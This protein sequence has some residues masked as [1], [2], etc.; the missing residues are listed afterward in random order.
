MP[1]CK[2]CCNLVEKARYNDTFKAT[3]LEILCAVI[4]QLQEMQHFNAVDNSLLFDAGAGLDIAAY[5]YVS[6]AEAATTDVYT[7]KT[8]GAGGTT[9]AT[10]TVSFSD[11]TK[12]KVVSVLKS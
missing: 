2:I 11:S 4:S 1:S 12:Q 9:V 10:V 6:V 3:T 5:D 7:Y 8:G